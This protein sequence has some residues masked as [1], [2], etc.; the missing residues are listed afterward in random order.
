[1]LRPK[2]LY[3]VI[4]TALLILA[5]GNSMMLF[6]DSP[7]LINYQGR[8]ANADGTPL[9][10]E[11][12][13]VFTIYDDPDLSELE[14][15]IWQESHPSLTVTDGL[16][17][18]LLG[19]LTLLNATHFADSARYLGIT[20]GEDQEIEPRTRIVTVA[21]AFQSV[22]SDSA[23]HAS[24]IADNAVTSPSIED[25]SINFTDIGPNGAA[26]GMIMKFDGAAWIPGPDEAGGTGWNWSDSSS[27]G[28][29]SVL[30]ADSSLYADSSAYA[31]SSGFAD[32]TEAITN[33]A[34]DFADIGQNGA[35]EGQVMK[36][37]SGAW[38]AADDETGGGGWIVAGNT[39]RLIEAN[40]SVGIGTITPTEKLDV[41]GNIH[42]SG[43]IKSG[44]S[45]I[46]DG[47]NSTITATSGTINFDD[48][49]LVTTG[50][51]TIGPGNVNTG[52][53]AF[54]AGGNNTATGAGS[55][56]SGGQTN[57]AGGATSAVG[58]GG[59]NLASGDF[60]TVSGGFGNETSGYASLVGGGQNNLASGDWST[61]GGGGGDTAVA[62][63][64][65]VSG[66]ANNM[67]GNTAATVG[68]G[69]YNRA[70]GMYSVVAG[71]GGENASDSSSA[72]GDWS[73]VSGGQQN[74]ANG[75]WSSIG[76]GQNNHADKVGATIAGGVGNYADGY[77]SA[78][79]GGNNNTA[80]G[81]WSTIGGGAGN[82]ASDTA[83]TVSGGKYNKAQGWYS[84]VAGGGG[85]D[86]V[87]SNSAS[88]HWSTISGG[89]SN[90]A[91]YGYTTVGGGY[92]NSAIYLYATVGGGGSDTASASAATVGGG[93]ENTASELYATIAGGYSNIASG[94]C[95]SV[96]G[97]R[98]N[99]ASDSGAI[100]AGGYAD[101]ASG[102]YATVAGGRANKASGRFSFA[103]GR[104]AKAIHDGSFVWCDSLN[105]ATSS[106]AP[107]QFYIRA[108]NGLCLAMAAGASKTIEVGDHYR[109]NGIVAWGKVLSSGSL[110]SEF[111]VNSVSHDSTGAYTITVDATATSSSTL[112][113]LA[114]AEVESAATIRIIS[115]NQ[116]S[117]S[118]FEVYINSSGFNRVDNDFMFMVTAR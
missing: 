77:M 16:F 115:V 82:M 81:R 84:V 102:A 112:I 47:N 99:V 87:D 36:W 3:Q 27:H 88:G 117:P 1:M 75:S 96:G 69:R 68:G 54:V 108:S 76:G 7:Q 50:Q 85:P 32:S 22:M 78:I 116:T 100:A 62:W 61:I 95:A 33:G 90:T 60:A 34:V 83:G 25:G 94:Y 105:L 10:G 20:V 79:G 101:T 14:N 91:L 19:S 13:M 106:T 113:P 11:Y 57:T 41:T 29:D 23:D 58:G 2:L 51:A 39:V 46:I 43:T 66:G 63:F 92:E 6:A 64:S 21:Y 44:S 118:T 30:F 114:V 55:V 56:V 9:N 52:A 31:K 89:R 18:V 8:L 109:D 103:A 72:L 17:N 71:G 53:N 49:N 67:A 48:E 4:P 111:G 65:T 24:S 93:F 42:A 45:I 59:Q 40:D 12:S 5:S 38:T 73:V 80:N 110:S 15:I 74:T 97:G 86:L 98:R 107:N 26:A 104:L 28:P 37:T 70:R 35:A